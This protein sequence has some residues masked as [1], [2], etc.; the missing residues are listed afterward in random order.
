MTAI[1]YMKAL[2]R[3]LLFS[4]KLERLI[5]G[6][7]LYGNMLSL[8]DTSPPRK[9]Q[10]SCIH[11]MRFLSMMW[12]LLS[13]GYGFVQ[14]IPA[15]L[16]RAY[17]GYEVICPFWYKIKS[18]WMTIDSSLLA[19]KRTVIQGGS[20]WLPICG[21]FLYYG[22]MSPCLSDLEGN[23]QNKW[24]AQCSGLDKYSNALYP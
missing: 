12:V 1:L 23:G 24:L 11:G 17:V 5:L 21:F 6:F 2:K 13:H 8:L 20:K 18:F 15:V 7:S 19:S 4:G 3:I 16:N 10:I 14:W 22:W 9:G